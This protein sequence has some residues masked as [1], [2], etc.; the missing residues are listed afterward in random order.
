M[1]HALEHVSR[2][3]VT[4]DNPRGRGAR[5]AL[6]RKEIYDETEVNN[7]LRA[8]HDDV[9]ALRRYLVE[10]GFVER[11]DGRYWRAGGTVGE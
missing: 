3:S 7:T 1:V 6:G 2:V 9:A 10:E 4:T 11:R 5:K 8:W